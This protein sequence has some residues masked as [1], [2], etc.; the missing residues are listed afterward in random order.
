M[1]IDETGQREHLRKIQWDAIKVDMD[2]CFTEEDALCDSSSIVQSLVTKA[3][4]CPRIKW[5]FSG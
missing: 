1:D 4:T 3:W 2:L 5:V